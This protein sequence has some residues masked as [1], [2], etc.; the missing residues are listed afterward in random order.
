MITYDTALVE[1]VGS[2]WLEQVSDMQLES[3]LSTWIKANGTQMAQTI[4]IPLADHAYT[5]ALVFSHFPAPYFLDSDSNGRV[6][7][8]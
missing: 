6:A 2:N 3:E 1:P 8:Y 7:S 5:F 4:N